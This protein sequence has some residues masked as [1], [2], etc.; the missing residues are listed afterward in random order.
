MINTT[1][2]TTKHFLQVAKNNSKKMIGKLT[3]NKETD[4]E[5][6]YHTLAK[7]S[8]SFAMVIQDLPEDLKDAICNFYLVLRA[9]DTIEDDMNLD[10][11]YKREL[12]ENFHLKCSDEKFFLQNVGDKPEYVELMENYPRIAAMFNSLDVNYQNV[13]RE[14]TLEMATGMLL[15]TTKE[16]ET[17][18]DYDLYCHYV[19]GLVGHGLSKI[20][21]ASGLEDK[22]YLDKLD[23]AN[24]MGL[25]L[26][27][28]NITRDYFEDIDEGRIFW[29]K[30][31][32]GDYTSDIYLLKTNYKSAKS[33]ACLNAMVVNAFLHF[34]DCITY[35][36]G[37]KNN[38]I[39]RF[40]A[41]PQ[42]MAVGT[43]SLL[44]NN[45][46]ALIKNIKV[47]KI[48]TM[49]IFA[50]LNTQQDFVDFTLKFLDQIQLK[51]AD[52]YMEVIKEQIKKDLKS[53]L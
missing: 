4:K 2:M 37:L 20:F 23:I 24:S 25:F 48:D 45:E 52:V 26:Q 28:T 47:N 51:D 15:F 44:Y 3:L 14:I 43:L 46:E 34:S 7:V 11:N 18:N 8:R 29:P 13:I 31:I 27:K 17:K 40:C 33:V 21:V 19:A 38:K 1:T 35:L 9:L 16:V 10:E 41:I 22:S 32:W 30:E 39:F 50:Q 5:Y 42:V 36:K 12:L 49:Q 53:I 6:C